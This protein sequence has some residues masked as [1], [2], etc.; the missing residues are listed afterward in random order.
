MNDKQPV[1]LLD[2]EIKPARRGTKMEIMLKGN[3]TLK[4][5]PK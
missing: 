2:C 5:Y 3:T 4:A 1:E